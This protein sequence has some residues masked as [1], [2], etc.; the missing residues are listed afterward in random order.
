[1]LIK[2]LIAKNYKKFGSKFFEFNDDVNILVGDNAM[3]KSSI[4]EAIE[5]ATN[6]AFRG[7][8]LTLETALELM[9][10]QAAAT[11]LA[12][13]LKYTT[14]PEML[15][16]I[17]L[18]GVP[19]YR[20]INNSLT[21][22]AQGVSL[23]VAF[24]MDLLAKYDE[25]IKTPQNV[26]S[27]PI[28]FYKIEWHDFAGNQVKSLTRKTNSLLIDPSRLH[29]TYGKNQYITAL[30][31]AAL[32]KEEL[33]HLNLDYRQL[34]H[35]FDDQQHVTQINKDLGDDKTITNGTLKI[36]ADIAASRGVEASLQLAVDDVAFPMVGKGEQSQIQIK[37]AIQNKAK[38]VNFILLEE[39][40]NHLSHMNLTRLISYIEK[41]RNGL[42]VF[43][44]THSSYV[45]NK[46]SIA[47]LCLVG[48]D[49]IRLKDIDPAI[50]VK[51][52]RLPGYDTLRAVL[53]NKVILVEGPS[54]ELILKKFYID[55]H[56]CLPE[57]DGIEIIVVR[58]L[59]FDTYLEI[60]KRIGVRT[61][62]LK[63]ND[64][65]YKAN[66]EAYQDKYKAYAHLQLLSPND[67][68]L[69]SLEPALIAEHNKTVA[70]LDSFAELILSLQTYNKY[71]EQPDLA[72]KTQFLRDWFGG[73]AG[74]G[75]KK[76]DSAMRIFDSKDAINY[77]A[78][79][80][81][82]FDFA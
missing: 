49:Y 53:A 17:Y 34:K 30:L 21:E 63:D 78:Y 5:L 10:A 15:I 61:N 65:D 71:K 39:P 58:G 41:N 52:K 9:N 8:T 27:V 7:K 36:I 16:E 19:E 80:V 75:K 59:G 54:D 14:L 11:Y 74:N 20:G 76:V 51:I 24:D 28:E 25:L 47:K 55:K 26:R 68:T 67:D 2:K 62:V 13:D 72:A 50:A 60:L 69:Y 44:S 56:K 79:L 81:G 18:E 40:E 23:R 12:G 43:I 4:L 57:D 38:S 46:L 6:C 32:S 70:S 42:Q 73:E 29:P 66:I 1:M 31:A 64:G 33:A 37:L 3:G 77:P 45:L 35:L 82:A 22:D 48:S